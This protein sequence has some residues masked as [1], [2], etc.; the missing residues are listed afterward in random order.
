MTLL[1]VV[2]VGMRFGGLQALSGVSLI[3]EKG[4]VSA[5]IGPNGAGKTTL[6]N[7]ISGFLRP[8]EG[9]VLFEGREIQNVPAFRLVSRGISRT[10]QNIRLLRDMTVLENVQLGHHCALRQTLWD[11]VFG[12][13]RHREE[14]EYSRKEALELLEF[15]GMAHLRDEPAGNLAYGFQRKL[16]IARILS[17]KAQLLLMDEPCAGMNPTEKEALAGL[18]TDI[19]QKMNKTVLL[20][21]HDMRFVMHLSKSRSVTV[22]NQGQKIAH[23]EPEE[24]QRNPLV[25]EAY[26]GHGRRR[27]DHARN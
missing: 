21:E 2:D 11:A 13:K 10:F 15:V 12:T 18:I 7:I 19:N 5:L 16:E 8:T 22:L 27:A 26:L 25:I 24:I 9:K 14:E 17:T 6:F 3:V 1:E 20:I 4:H 23:G